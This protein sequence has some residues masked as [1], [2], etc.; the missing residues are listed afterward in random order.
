MDT[1]RWMHF[2]SSFGWAFQ[3]SLQNRAA[4]H[5]HLPSK[6]AWAV[7]LLPLANPL[8]WTPWARG[9]ESRAQC[10]CSE[11]LRFQQLHPPE[12]QEQTQPSHSYTP[13]YKA[14]KYNIF[15]INLL[16]QE[17]SS[18]GDIHSG[19]STYTCRVLSIKAPPLLH[20]SPLWLNPLDRC[21][22][23]PGTVPVN[24]SAGTTWGQHLDSLPVLQGKGEEQIS[25]KKVSEM[26]C[27]F[28][29]SWLTML[30]KPSVLGIMA[31]SFLLF[32]F[33]PINLLSSIYWSI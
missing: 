2:K 31:C 8:C 32:F 1:A 25:E 30:L 33:F 27:L 23:H 29:V 6:H 24:S 15:P 20:P 28:K 17:A 11:T 21:Y 5:R 26:C 10:C 22:I 4:H 12:N 9:Q 13:T 18:R 3:V 19:S 7:P 16:L 14:E